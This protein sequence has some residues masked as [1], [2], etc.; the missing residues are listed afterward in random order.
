LK[1]IITALLLNQQQLSGTLAF[2]NR[3]V[4]LFVLYFCV[5]ETTLCF[6]SYA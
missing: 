5:T 4:L 6:Q 3:N 2:Q 1:E